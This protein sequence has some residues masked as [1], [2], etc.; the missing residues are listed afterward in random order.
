[1][2]TPRRFYIYTVAAVSLQVVTWSVIM[3]VRNLLV[4]ELDP[5]TATIAFQVAIILIGLP[6][7]LIHWRW[8]QQISIQD[9]EERGAVL[10]RLFLYG[11][12]AAF[13]GS[14]LFS[15]YRLLSAA[16][17]A[18]V[19]YTPPRSYSPLS[20][21]G[22]V[23]YHTLGIVA[24]ALVCYAL[25]RMIA[26]DVAIVPERGGAAT[27]RRLFVLGFSAAGLSMSSIAIV[28]I[29]RWLL[30]LITGDEGVS[31]SV[32]AGPI[33][34]IARLIVGLPT[35][36][37]FWRWA[38]TLFLD[39]VVE[40]RESALRKFFLYT[41]VF[42]AVLT[43]VSSATL[44]LEGLF[45]R[46]LAVSAT[47]AGQGDI[48]VPLSI[49]IVMAALWGYHAALIRSD[50]Q[51]VQEAPRQAGLRRLYLY[52]VAGIGL[53]AFLVGISGIVSTLIRALG[54]AGF[55]VGLK[56]QVSWSTAI[57]LAGLPVWALP[58]R[59]VHDQSIVT[60]KEGERER[61]SLVRKIY[62]YFFLLIAM[63]TMLSSL[64]YVVFRILNMILGAPP[65]SLLNLGQPIAFSL[66]ALGVLL[67]HGSILRD[68]RQRFLQDQVAR[69]EGFKTVLL[70]L[71]ESDLLQGILDGLARHIPGMSPVVIGQ[72]GTMKDMD[73]AT[74]VSEL[75]QADLIVGP[76]S[77]AL[78]DGPEDGVT[79]GIA[80][81]VSSSSAQKILI[82]NRY[83]GWEWAGVDLWDPEAMA[84]QTVHAI[85][86]ILEGETAR[87]VRPLGAGAILGIV[88]G[89]LI[90]LSL[91][92]M[93][94]I[95]FFL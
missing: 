10:R 82:P 69:H 25:Y 77:V 15:T 73:E 11:M 71:G 36:I 88:I 76:W 51:L 87:P 31:I 86:Q 93:P 23:L 43:A 7:F 41:V 39:G 58:W 59:Q 84:R 3:L 33:F 40:E 42:I 18:M 95:E 16:L 68:D 5:P 91:I 14:V 1:M 62:L 61:S 70:D 46:I 80:N 22:T 45:R 57:V 78:P 56:R 49:I 12:L 79:A 21:G 63:L 26:E 92:V 64:V 44:I 34:E 67:Y 24:L 28:Q 53:A 48:R 65:P 83:E 6:V 9:D 4:F 47:G 27:V 74:V 37:L 90:L 2:F 52:L 55:G 30:F 35:W 54:E 89:V 17:A 94:L 8:G 72:Q 13:L 85:Q 75:Q 19:R 38:Q 81:A 60:G 66:I 20:H 32:G 50:T 29:L